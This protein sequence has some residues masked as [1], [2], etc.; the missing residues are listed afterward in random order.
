VTLGWDT[1]RILAVLVRFFSV[2]QVASRREAP[3]ALARFLPAMRV[4]RR[5]DAALMVLA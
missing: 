5:Q 1:G 3:A 2:L 4:M